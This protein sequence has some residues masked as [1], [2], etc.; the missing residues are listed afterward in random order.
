MTIKELEQELNVPR[1]TIRFYEKQGL[2][3]PNRKGNSYRDYSENDLIAL[4]K[5]IIFRKIG[6]SVQ[7]IEDLFGGANLSEAIDQTILNLET[8]IREL[9]GSLEI[10]RKIKKENAEFE[11]FD[12]NYYWQKIIQSETSGKRYLDISKDFLTYEKNDITETLHLKSL[13]KNGQRKIN[14]K[15]V[16]IFG[17][18]MLMSGLLENFRGTSIVKGIFAPI[19]FIMLLTIFE[20]PAFF[21][22]EKHSSAEKWFRK[23]G[24]MIAAIG[25]IIYIV[26]FWGNIWRD[27]LLRSKAE[28]SILYNMIAC[29]AFLTWGFIYDILERRRIFDRR[30]VTGVNSFYVLTFGGLASGLFIGMYSKPA[31]VS[32]IVLLVIIYQVLYHFIEEKAYTEEEKFQKPQ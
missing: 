2:I 24:Y 25:L 18:C 11:T 29:A 17:G 8:Q 22:K 26:S 31:C 1:A 14:V 7:E 23:I 21:L 27:L 13:E 6:F 20:I 5:I 10:C 30:H 3:H 4:K 32:F 12:E 28:I 16:F 15:I 9:N 19:L